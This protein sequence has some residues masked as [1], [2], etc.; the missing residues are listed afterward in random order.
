M[1]FIVVLLM[2]GLLVYAASGLL[3]GVYVS[4][5]FEAIIVAVLLAIVN[6]FIK[7]IITILTLPVTILTLG[8]FLLIINA[9]MI[10]LV[11][12][13]LDGFRVDGWFSAIVF[14]ILLAI[15]NLVFGGFDVRTRTYHP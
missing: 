2:N 4:S 11:D 13:L 9:G 8:F 10:L 14:S 15:F 12:W 3:S 1:R 5:Y 7:P 6:T